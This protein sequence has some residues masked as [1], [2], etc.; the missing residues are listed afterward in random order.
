MTKAVKLNLVIA[1][2]F[3]LVAET[4]CI[5]HV[6]GLLKFPSLH[7]MTPSSVYTLTLDASN[8]PK[9]QEFASH[10]VYNPSGYGLEASYSNAS[11]LP[12][13]HVHLDTNG[14]LVMK[15]NITGVYAIE[16]TFTGGVVA[17]F[18]LNNNTLATKEL[19]SGSLVELA[20][21]YYFDQIKL[22]A[23]EST[24]IT[25]V[26]FLYS[27]SEHEDQ[28]T[29]PSVVTSNGGAIIT[30]V[31][32]QT[33]LGEKVYLHVEPFMANTVES[34][35]LNGNP[36][37]LDSES[38]CYVYEA[39]LNDEVEVTTSLQD[40]ITVNRYTID[41]DTGESTF[42]DTSK[43]NPIIDPK[44]YYYTVNA[45]EMEG[46]SPDKD[47]YKSVLDSEHQV[48][49]FY[50]SKL[51]V[52]D[53]TESTSLSGSGT[54][55]SPYLIKSAA[56]YVYFA[57]SVA[58]NLYSG[59]YLKM[60]KSVD[61]SS[62]P[63]GSVRA[64]LSG[65]QFRG[66]FDGNN[67]AIR[68]V[69]ITSGSKQALFY[70]IHTGIVKNL[71][72]YGSNKSGMCAGSL[73]SYLDAGGTI[74]NCSNYITVEH[75]KAL[76]DSKD[77]GNAAGGFVG[78]LWTNGKIINCTNYANVTNID[79]VNDTN[80]TA[81]IVGVVEKNGGLIQNTFNFGNV[82]GR[83][84]A[85][86]I[87]P[88]VNDG[89][90]ITLKDVYNFGDVSTSQVS[91]P[92]GIMGSLDLNYHNVDG[93]YNFGDVISIA[94][95]TAAGCF[96]TVTVSTA[97]ENQNTVKNC[98]NFGDVSVTVAA[99]GGIAAYITDTNPTNPVTFENCKNYGSITSTIA[100]NS[101]VGGIVGRCMVELSS[102]ATAVE[103]LVTFDSCEN[104]GY[105]DG[106]QRSG[107][108]VGWA[109][110]ATLTNCAN[111]GD[112]GT[113]VDAISNSWNGGLV[114]TSFNHST[115]KASVLTIVDSKNF[116]NIKASSS[117]VG[118]I[119]GSPSG[120]ATLNIDN[121]V[122][123]GR[124]TSENTYAGGITGQISGAALSA[125][126]ANCTNY[127]RIS[128]STDYCGGVYCNTSAK[129]SFTNNVNYGRLICPG[130]HV[131]NN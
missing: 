74:Q 49:N 48:A 102:K 116:G 1:L 67:C 105:I 75:D 94:G 41:E 26:R 130:T 2:S 95:S 25:S 118:G 43:V 108:I 129:W 125:S 54:A 47:Y 122:N 55:A 61:I 8:A 39:G 124:V 19:T 32:D 99:V 65:H 24:D 71:C 109:S 79:T 15:T 81:G 92:S 80:K 46:Y 104:Y 21:G 27:C 83:K 107:G 89:F 115:T 13:G 45:P 18:G 72:T 35:T 77:S 37:A 38:G 123:Y 76:G 128:A 120:N 111:Y 113:D 119:V 60:T 78:S 44:G 114:G 82:S 28:T 126:I 90:T 22:F 97:T 112:F 40:K 63:T 101:A 110:T 58:T 36:L 3:G 7:E 6:G 17:S 52:Y 66:T 53:G 5:A 34:V 23:T 62:L 64:G 117:A 91:V 88:F 131:Y 86:G 68:G 69:T 30:G 85:G 73:C 57:K 56:D 29:E 84:M 59:K 70:S 31:N 12:G 51:D 16:P 87:A 42:V 11:E 50:Y 103:R 93:C 121:C 20:S 10:I 127:G 96:N 4:V 100:A 9:E 33:Y 98:Y 106:A 14:E